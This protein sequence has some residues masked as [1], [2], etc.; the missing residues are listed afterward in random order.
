MSLPYISTVNR[1]FEVRGLFNWR[2]VKLRPG[3]RLYAAQL[4]A[5]R[6]EANLSTG[7]YVPPRSRWQNTT[8]QFRFGRKCACSKLN[9]HNMKL[10][11]ELFYFVSIKINIPGPTGLRSWLIWQ[12]S[13]FFIRNIILVRNVPLDKRCK[14][15]FYVQ[16]PLL[17]TYYFCF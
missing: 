6:S 3:R 11:F 8:V 7:R 9:H 13:C 15:G 5:V 17:E 4:T 10:V 12:R 1:A 16:I 2:W 14:S